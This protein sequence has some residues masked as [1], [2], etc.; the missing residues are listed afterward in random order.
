VGEQVLVHRGLLDSVALQG[1]GDGGQFGFGDDEVTHDQGLAVAV[2]GE[3]REAAQREPGFDGHAVGGDG[4]VAAGEADP[5]HGAGLQGAGPGPE[6]IAVAVLP[7]R[8]RRV[9]APSVVS[10]TLRVRGSSDIVLS[11]GMDFVA[12]GEWL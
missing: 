11:K 9:A 12:D 5:E 1:I 7:V 2:A 4:E 6:G 8:T 3:H 10:L